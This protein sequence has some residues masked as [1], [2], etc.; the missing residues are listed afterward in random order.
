[1][2]IL[3]LLLHLL[4]VALEVVA[5]GVEVLVV[6]VAGVVVPLLEALRERRVLQI[7]VMPVGLEALILLLIARVAVAVAREVLDSPH[8]TPLVVEAEV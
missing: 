6:L 5:L 7:K 4:V 2:V 1:L 3:P 8:Q